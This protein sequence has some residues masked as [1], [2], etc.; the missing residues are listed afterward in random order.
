MATSTMCAPARSRVT[1][2]SMAALPSLTCATPDASSDGGAVVAQLARRDRELVAR[3]GRPRSPPRR[4][5]AAAR[6]PPPP[7]PRSRG[8]RSRRP[9]PSRRRRDGVDGTCSAWP[10]ASRLACDASSGGSSRRPSLTT[11]TAA[12]RSSGDAA[13]ARIAAPRSL[14]AAR[15]VCCSAARSLSV[16]GSGDGGPSPKPRTVRRA[17]FAAF[18]SASTAA[19]RVFHR[20]P[21]GCSSAID[22]E[23]S[24]ST[25]T[26]AP[27]TLSRA[28]T[29]AGRSTAASSPTT[30]SRPVT[31]M[32]RPPRSRRRS[33]KSS[34]TKLARPSP[35]ASQ[36]AHGAMSPDGPRCVVSI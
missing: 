21:P 12:G 28:D 32:S 8:A 30:A 26:R 4:A 33:S 22:R 27:T 6:A 17:L 36:Q 23:V 15:V 9:A 10:R 5:A 34:I 16:S 14:C 35:A 1:V 2:R 31:V 19:S 29:R 3:R 13:S 20:G 24:A 7:R 11:T 25:T 18:A